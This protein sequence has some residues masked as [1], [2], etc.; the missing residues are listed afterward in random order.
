[1]KK[2]VTIRSIVIVLVL[3]GVF[4]TFYY[5]NSNNFNLNLLFNKD[6]ETLISKGRRLLDQRK[7]EDAAIFF[8]NLVKQDVSPIQSY[9]GRGDAFLGLRRLDEAIRDYSKSLGYGKTVNVLS[10]RCNAY[11]IYS[12]YD[13]ATKDCQEALSIE[14]VN[15]DALL[16]SILL[17]IDQQKYDDARILINRLIDTIPESS[18]GYYALAQLQM[19]EGPSID[20]IE[21]LSMAINLDPDQIQYY[22]DRG[23]LYYSNGM[24]SEAKADMEKINKI[25]NPDTDGELLVRA[26]TLLNSF[27]GFLQD[28]PNP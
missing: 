9:Y 15:Q 1:M 28:N 12:K 19:V 14:P 5:L 11:R 10:S 26:N 27:S 25:A 22:W 8:H 24:I 21:S 7:Y 2:A 4:L 23:F 18:I 20:A 3:L 16:S 6:P 17:F 13:E